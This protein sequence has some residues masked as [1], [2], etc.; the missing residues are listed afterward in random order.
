MEV[1]IDG[2]RYVPENTIPTNRDYPMEYRAYY[3]RDNYRFVNITADT[4]EGML[5]KADHA[6]HDTNGGDGMLCPVHLLNIN[7]RECRRVGMGYHAPS[8]DG[9]HEAEWRDAKQQWANAL[10]SDADM[11]RLLKIE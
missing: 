6:F 5:V 2:V 3:M 11:R 10:E 7:G 9:H 8:N 1:I 4:I